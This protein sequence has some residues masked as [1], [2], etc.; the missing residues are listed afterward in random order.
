MFSFETYISSLLLVLCACICV[1]LT[2]LSRSSI[3]LL[4]TMRRPWI[5]V[6][7]SNSS[8]QGC[9]HI[10]VDP[11]YTFAP[12]TPVKQ[13]L[14]VIHRSRWT[15]CTGGHI[16]MYLGVLVYICG[17]PAQ[18]ATAYSGIKSQDKSL[19]GHIPVHKQIILVV[20]T[21]NEMHV[22]LKTASWSSTFQMI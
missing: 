14:L 13:Y 20:A 9:W 7:K 19:R 11:L 8:L 10:F 16:W 12:S 22:S 21:E 2:T 6:I 1:H 4:V 5:S 15:N 17:I 3:R 18:K